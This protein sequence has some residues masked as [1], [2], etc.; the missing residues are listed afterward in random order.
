[1]QNSLR[2]NAQLSLISDA[3]SRLLTHADDV[4][5]VGAI[6][7]S[8]TRIVEAGVAELVRRDVTVDGTVSLFWLTT[9]QVL[10]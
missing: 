5:R 9:S 1:M 8:R 3:Q 7:L 4:D 2:S 10:C 6:L